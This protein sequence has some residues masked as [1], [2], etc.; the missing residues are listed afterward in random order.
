MSDTVSSPS[1]NFTV[2]QTQPA[3]L[4]IPE[5][6][7]R[8][9]IGWAIGRVR[10]KIGTPDDVVDQLFAFVPHDTREQF[11]QWLLQN[12]NIY[13]DVS[14]PRDPVSLAMIVVEPQSEAEDTTS[15]FLGD[16]VGT[17][18]RGQ[19][20][21]QTVTESLAYGIPEIHNTNIY[22]ASDDD[23]LTLFLYTLVKFIVLHNKAS[24]DRFY[25]V[26]NLSLSGGVLEHDTDRMPQ[27]VYYRV[28]QARYMT[29][30]DFNGDASSAI[31]SVSLG[32]SVAEFIDGE[33]VDTVVEPSV[34]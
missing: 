29:I 15:T 4:R 11:K 13:L 26:H 17:T 20:S 12:Q 34:T 16:S 32:L 22:I 8:Q 27:F 25:D 18:I 7:I 31:A 10:E 14:W 1:S 24:L 2:P 28:L 6:A 33:E 3:G 5:F 9:L 21:G 23:R 19:F 30:F